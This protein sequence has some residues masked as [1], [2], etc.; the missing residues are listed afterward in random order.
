MPR[1]LNTYM[2]KL[3]S[4]RPGSWY[5]ARTL[6]HFD[7]LF[8]KLT[9][10]LSLTGILMGLPVV[11]VTSVGAKSGLPRTLP[12]LAIT[13]GSDPDTLAVVASN[14]GQQ[15]YPAWYFNLKANP[16]ATCSINGRSGKYTAHEAIGEE[17]DHFWRC[18]IDTYIGYPVYRQRAA[19]RRIPI[20]VLKKN[21]D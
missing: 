17:Y 13:D 16:Q 5:F 6:H 2:Q 7:R 8:L 4:S 20:M 10:R 15:H 18:A 1:N 3:A 12:L 14:Y 9:G 21:A 11:F 19:A